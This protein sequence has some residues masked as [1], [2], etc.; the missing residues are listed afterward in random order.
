[1]ARVM[2]L[3][4]SCSRARALPVFLGARGRTRRPRSSGPCVSILHP[5]AR[6]F[7]KLDGAFAILDQRVFLAQH[8]VERVPGFVHHRLHVLVHPRGVH[9]DERPTRPR[10]LPCTDSPPGAFPFPRVQVQHRPARAATGFFAAAQPGEHLLQARVQAA[11]GRKAL[12]HQVP[13]ALKERLERGPRWPSLGSTP[14]SHLK[15][16]RAE[17]LEPPKPASYQAPA[18]AG[19]TA[20]STPA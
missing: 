16:R 10:A 9:E 5:H 14:K 20:A 1:M 2:T 12:V 4:L 17:T 7:G 3:C 15:A 19:A 8:R 11:E 18:P 13:P 6:H